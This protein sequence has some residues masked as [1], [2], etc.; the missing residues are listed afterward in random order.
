[1]LPGGGGG[2][3]WAHALTG[4]GEWGGG[5][6]AKHPHFTHRTPTGIPASHPPPSSPQPLRGAADIPSSPRPPPPSMMGGWGGGGGSEQPPPP[7]RGHSPIWGVCAGVLSRVMR[8][9]CRA[10]AAAGRGGVRGLGGGE[11]RE[12]PPDPTIPPFPPPHN[13]L[14]LPAL[15]EAKAQQ[16]SGSRRRPGGTAGTDGAELR[17]AAPRTPPFPPPYPKPH[18]RSAVP[19]PSERGHGAIVR[20][21]SGRRRF[22]GRER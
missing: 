20:Q 17:A 4:G 14:P 7:T 12:P 9:G 11:G 3:R 2:G 10:M 22:M 21:R 18:P 16:S 15:P 5:A 1:M 6:A 13:A 19:V 8:G